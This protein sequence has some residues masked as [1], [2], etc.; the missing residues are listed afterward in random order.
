MILKGMKNKMLAV[1]LAAA[2]TVT[3][4]P[5]VP[6][7]AMPE[8][9][10]AVGVAA[11]ELVP[12]DSQQAD[13]EEQTSEEADAQLSDEDQPDEGTAAPLLDE[14]K[15][16]AED[17]AS[18]EYSE[19]VG[20]D[21]KAVG[22]NGVAYEDVAYLSLKAY[23]S[24]S[25]DAQQVYM[26]MCDS[27]TEWKEGGED[28]RNIVISLD[29]EGALR[30]GV[31]MP[32]KVFTAQDVQG[33]LA[34]EPAVENT[35]DSAE[36][37]EDTQETAD[38]EE[39][40]TEDADNSD[41][42]GAEDADNSDDAQTPD[43]GNT[44][45]DNEETNGDTANGDADNAAD[46][47]NSDGNDSSADEE[48]KNDDA[49]TG[50]DTPVLDEEPADSEN[51]DAAAE[52][53]ITAEEASNMEESVEEGIVAENVELADTYY[54][55]DAY[56]DKISTVDLDTLLTNDS[57]FKKQL[58]GFAKTLYD[59][60]KKFFV[61]E[62]GNWIGYELKTPTLAKPAAFSA[63]AV[64]SVSAL[65]NMY[66]NKFNWTD[67][68][69]SSPLYIEMEYMNG[70]GTYIVALAQSKHYSAALESQADAKVNELVD[71][72]VQYA[73]KEYPANP[74]WGIIEYFDEWI[75]K[76]NFYNDIGTYNDEASRASDTY[77]YCHSCY[78][79]LLK[80][81]GV[82]ESYALA[83]TRLL[84]AAGIRNQY[85]MGEADGGGH[86]WNY[87]Q[88]PD[89]NWYMLDSTWNDRGS[90]SSKD[91]F[92]VADDGVHKPT[93]KR[94]VSG[95][96][97]KFEKLSS[98]YYVEPDK[99][100]IA[101]KVKGKYNMSIKDSYYSKM[102]SEWSSED[103]A[104]AKI[105]QN[106]QITA[107]S[108]TGETVINVK[109]NN[110]S[111][112]SVPV[113]VFQ[114]ASLTFPQTGKN[115]Y[116]DTYADED[117]YI[118]IGYDM[119][120]ISID[121]NQ[122]N[123]SIS[124]QKLSECAALAPVVTSGNKKVAVAGAELVGDKIELYVFPLAVGKSKI[125]V[126]FADK[127]ASYTLNVKYQLQENWFSCESDNTTG[128][129]YTGKAY[130]PKVTKT[131]TE[132]VGKDAKYKV[133][134]ADNKNAGIA[135][136]RISGTGNYAGTVERT[137]RINPIAAPAGDVQ[138]V[139]CAE[140][141]VYSG[142]GQ[143]PKSKV[144]V[145]SKT[146]KAG[147]DYI[148][149]YNGSEELPKDVGTYTVTIKGNNYN[150]NTA[151]VEPKTLTITETTL[152]K[153]KVTC[154]SSLKATGNNLLPAIKDKIIVKIGKNVLEEGEDYTVTFSDGSGNKLSAIIE[155]GTYQV[156]FE[157]IGDNVKASAKK[158]SIVK[159]IKV[160]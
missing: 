57:Y 1:L 60:G 84:D 66:P 116:T 128:Y 70:R 93:G 39:K 159:T 108:K 63:A 30:L 136:V 153:V 48:G 33:L 7:M 151:G 87:V 3:A 132:G 110:G 19:N 85:I 125:T 115:S 149:L 76:N 157:P 152:D 77:F 154:P 158:S 51:N 133:T 72:A 45:A 114:I 146:L 27:I 2:V 64:D 65:I 83:M 141:L 124:A 75:C 22:T 23:N 94:F 10:G 140:S 138:F 89:N 99:T 26:D 126:K 143:T 44:S 113:Y 100:A 17:E 29:E 101:I 52:D 69:T 53:K 111:T 38:T 155:K 54:N 4:V 91:Y 135:T 28:V 58:S 107:G 121:V 21:T 130:K 68:G 104:V 148:L 20:I 145:G 12:D 119:V 8:D 79:I 56:A 73:L 13:S 32:V 98:T 80:G 131:A 103:T 78:G 49:N 71:K 90:S 40:N 137:F 6:V 142:A 37:K 36:A 34:E 96:T 156:T 139:S 129:D 160:K 97:F 67:L 150:L 43:D 74:T 106:G 117:A 16:A 47:E 105:D 25:E 112:Y 147:A 82:C 42:A 127:S 118:N 81:Y 9:G 95:K 88:M 24:L 46:S 92:L 62:Y 11:E 31:S 109:L 50:D 41:A 144:K 122:N 14:A 18:Y 55:M 134:Y 59:T 61:D 35:G 123:R 5:S 86:A 102:V 120:S 15:E